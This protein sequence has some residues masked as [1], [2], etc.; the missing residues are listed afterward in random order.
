MFH[1]VQ[2]EAALTIDAVTLIGQTMERMARVGHND[3]KHAG[4]RGRF[5]SNG[6]YGVDCEADPPNP[7][8]LG[9]TVVE[10]MKNVSLMYAM[11]RMT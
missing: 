4:P 3:F 8:K 6:S 10:A 9:K 1:R 5:S 2:Y 7:W 11:K